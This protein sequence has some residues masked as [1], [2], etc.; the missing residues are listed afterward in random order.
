MK[1]KQVMIEIR[2]D[3]KSVSAA[4]G[5]SLLD[6]CLENGIYIPN[7]C[8]IKGMNPPPVSCRLCF[9]EIDGLPSPVPACI[10]P[11]G[12]GMIVRTDT[13]QVR[14]LQRTALKLLLSAHR[15]ECRKCPANPGCPL[16]NMARFLKT[17]LKS[18]PFE[19]RLKSADIDD[20]HPVLAYYPNRCVLC[21]RCIYVCGNRNGL[22]KIAFAGRGFDTH[23]CITPGS[24]ADEEYCRECREC[25]R[26][27][28]VAALALKTDPIENKP[29]I[30]LRS[31]PGGI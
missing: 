16:Q 9:V 12:P 22:S 27:C 4:P 30:D 25:Q 13:P 14:A 28:P 1:A 3:E 15:I 5:K 24:P 2:I 8:H 29:K 10:T 26:I 18:H 31:P 6:T 19:Q 7:L 20:S 17:G 11:V 23:L 21:G